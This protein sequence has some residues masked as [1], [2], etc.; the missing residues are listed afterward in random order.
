MEKLKILLQE[1]KIRKFCNETIRP[2]LYY[3][4]KFLEFV[5]KSPLDIV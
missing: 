2:Y 1:M 5:K 3:N 4:N